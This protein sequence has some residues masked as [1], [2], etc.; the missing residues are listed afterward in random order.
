MLCARPSCS[1]KSLMTSLC[2]ALRPFIFFFISCRSYL[3]SL[4]S[5]TPV[6]PVMVSLHSVA[7][8]PAAVF[9]CRW[10]LSQPCFS[11]ACAQKQHFHGGA[12]YR[13]FLSRSQ[14]KGWVKH[15]THAQFRLA[16]CGR[17]LSSRTIPFF[18]EQRI[19][20]H[21]KKQFFSFLNAGLRVQGQEHTANGVRLRNFPRI[22][23]LQK[24]IMSWNIFY[25]QGG[26]LTTLEED[27][28]QGL[29]LVLKVTT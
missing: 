22:H 20:N 26:L 21:K 14:A 16:I 18:T 27:P 19:V 5:F 7:C 2:W 15:W 13:S 12:W 28:S 17:D 11:W 24:Y 23:H 3:T 9:C 10:S 1:F 8:L 6:S 25:L 4:L 29:F